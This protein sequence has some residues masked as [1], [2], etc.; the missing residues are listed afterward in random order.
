MKK[1]IT[2]ALTLKPSIAQQEAD[3]NALQ[4]YITFHQGGQVPPPDETDSIFVLVTAVFEG[5]DVSVGLADSAT[6]EKVTHDA[7]GVQPDI[8]YVLTDD[9]IEQLERDWLARYYDDNRDVETYYPDGPD[10]YDPYG[11]GNEDDT[12][13]IDPGSV[14]HY[15][16]IPPFEVP[17]QYE[18]D[19]VNRHGIMPN[20]VAGNNQP[21]VIEIIS[22]RSTVWFSYPGQ[23]PPIHYNQ[24]KVI[25]ILA[26]EMHPCG[27]CGT[28]RYWAEGRAAYSE[29]IEAV[30]Q[31]I[32]EHA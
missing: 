30:K 16:D 27:K 18:T 15:P 11:I 2:F 20:A 13:D 8:M 22:A 17:T 3:Y 21:D 4:E 26:Q 25:E 29:I 19:Y 14:T 5:G 31:H 28:G 23:I 9:Q 10:E 32:N 12:M 24:N 1:Q 6:I 7:P